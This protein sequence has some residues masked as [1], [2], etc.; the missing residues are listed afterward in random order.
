MSNTIEVEGLLG[1]DPELR[2]TN[3][4]LAIATFNLA[5]SPRKYNKET[6]KYEDAGETAWFRVSVLGNQAETV[7][8]QF[9][10]GQPVMVK[11]TLTFRSWDDKE[12]NKR[13]SKEIKSD[14]VYPV[15]R[16]ARS[17]SSDAAAGNKS[18][19]VA[20]AA[21]DDESPF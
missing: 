19:P 21:N 6:Q 20:A 10:K 12:G 7:A 4:G 18:A 17:G 8:A 5:D 16:G 11:G 9:K 3:D 14:K 15:L 13:E 1:G 2:Y